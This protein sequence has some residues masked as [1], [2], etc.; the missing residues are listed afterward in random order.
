VELFAYLG[1]LLAG[2]RGLGKGTCAGATAATITGG[3]AA[4][5]IELPTGAEVVL[6]E[7]TV[8]ADA[9]VDKPSF[10]RLLQRLKVQP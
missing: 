4:A 10:S 8:A 5:A 9:P 7:T 1:T 2:G 3:A 6:C